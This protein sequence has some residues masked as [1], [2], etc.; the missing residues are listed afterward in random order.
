MAKPTCA[1]FTD[2]PLFVTDVPDE[3]LLESTQAAFANDVRTQGKAKGFNNSDAANGA[4]GPALHADD[5]H[6]A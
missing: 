2:E 1:P 3:E 4:N 5:R 6:D